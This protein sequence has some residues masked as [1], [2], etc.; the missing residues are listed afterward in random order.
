MCDVKEYKEIY[1]KINNLTSAETL[2]LV[3]NSE[4]EEQQE[5]FELIDNY[6]LQKRQRKAIERNMF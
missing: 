2:D 3:L 4:D 1:D 5:F 6:L